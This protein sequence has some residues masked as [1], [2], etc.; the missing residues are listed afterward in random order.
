MDEP[1]EKSY[2]GDGVYAV[3]DYPHVVLTAENGIEASDTIYL[4]E[5]TL[6]ALERYVAHKRK[7]GHL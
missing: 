4:D 3:L 7:I 2:L 6:A 1:N 5:T